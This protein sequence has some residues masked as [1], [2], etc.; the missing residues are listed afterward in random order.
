[1][2]EKLIEAFDHDQAVAGVIDSRVFERPGV[3]VR[4]E[5][6]AEADRECGIDV[7]FW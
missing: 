6:G 1:M 3:R 2:V 7:G 4:D 5:D